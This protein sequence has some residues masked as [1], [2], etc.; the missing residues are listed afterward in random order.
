MLNKRKNQNQNKKNFN[1]ARQFFYIFK[2]KQIKNK[3]QF[4]NR[5]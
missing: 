3:K 5:D 4:C 1:T 2:E